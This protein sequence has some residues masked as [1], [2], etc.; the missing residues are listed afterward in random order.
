M[1]WVTSA[2]C[3]RGKETTEGNRQFFPV[4]ADLELMTRGL[5]LQ[6]R[7]IWMNS[8]SVVQLSENNPPAIV[9]AHTRPTTHTISKQHHQRPAQSPSHRRFP[10][11]TSISGRLQNKVRVWVREDARQLQYVGRCGRG[12][13]TM[14]CGKSDRTH[15]SCLCERVEGDHIR[16]ASC[17]LHRQVLN[18]ATRI[19]FAFPP[20]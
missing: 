7:G 6:L 12:R 20:C 11:T 16:H 5:H 4:L 8:F 3:T 1:W 15:I 19:H 14:A 13:L 18:G 9:L 2:S 10:Q 17:R